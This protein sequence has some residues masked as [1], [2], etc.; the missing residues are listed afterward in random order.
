MCVFSLVSVL[1]R[2]V[3][4]TKPKFGEGGKRPLPPD[5]QAKS[6]TTKKDKPSFLTSNRSQKS[7]QITSVKQDSVKRPHSEVENSKKVT[8]NKRPAIERRESDLVEYLS[9][10]NLS[11]ILS[12]NEIIPSSAPN[13]SVEAND[14][15]PS[16][17]IQTKQRPGAR[18]NLDSLSPLP[19]HIN[20]VILA[21]VSSESRLTT[22]NP[23]KIRLGI[24]TIC[25]PVE[26][27]EYQ[28]S[29]A[30]IIT[31]KS[32][33]QI[34][35][36][37][38]CNN[39]PIL[40]IPI[41]A[42]IA[43]TS[44]F[45]YA[46]IWAP[47]LQ[48]ESNE[49][50]LELLKPQNVITVRKMFNDK[51]PDSNRNKLPLYVLTFLG[52]V[53]TDLKIGYRN[54]KTEKYYPSPMQCRKCWR[55][56]H[57]TTACRSRT[58]NCFKCSSSEH[59]GEECTSSEPKCINCK[60]SHQSSDRGCPTYILEKEICTVTA[61]QGCSFAEARSIVNHS[62]A[63]VNRSEFVYNSQH[64]PPLPPPVARS[65]NTSNPNFFKAPSQNSQRNHTFSSITD[66]LPTST[67]K[68]PKPQHLHQNRASMYDEESIPCG[69]S[70]FLPQCQTKSTIDDPFELLSMSPIRKSVSFQKPSPHQNMQYTQY[71]DSNS[72]TKSQETPI[73]QPI[74]NN[75]IKSLPKLIPLIIKA[76]FTSDQCERIQCLTNIGELLNL[77][78][79]F[80]AAL[81][82]IHL[83]D[84]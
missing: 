28:R 53:P 49:E 13:N 3:M 63:Q 16:P 74:I 50:I 44:Q 33:D 39:F 70:E 21:S 54:I 51:D 69:Q 24:H 2:H 18:I 34:S 6:A 31:V 73:Y 43:W 71:S 25:G 9:D 56:A 14:P 36:L 5:P 61:D 81:N 46:K 41:V 76:M 84:S 82:S 38:N 77:G 40:N 68:D 4:A 23:E 64:Y 79:I 19:D 59:S 10:S 62:K 15:T 29:G 27:V 7:K 20:K 32:H 48:R 72:S 1:E 78:E 35:A 67:R 57:S 60:G 55:F 65:S 52:N 42:K 11:G 47:E 12:D 37:K 30:L 80:S 8:K 83:Y 75:I 17:I 58:K 66:S 22:F 26:G 45:T